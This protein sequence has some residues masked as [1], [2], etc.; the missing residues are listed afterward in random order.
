MEIYIYKFLGQR[1]NN[2]WDERTFSLQAYIC[3]WR[4]V[5]LMHG[6]KSL[7]KDITY[8]VMRFSGTSSKR[9]IG[10]NV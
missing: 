3:V 7:R 9:Y 8:A 1:A 2:K 6:D 5:K 10:K 4:E